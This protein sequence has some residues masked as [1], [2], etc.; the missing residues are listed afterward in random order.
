MAHKGRRNRQVDSVSPIDDTSPA[1]ISPE[2]R[3]RTIRQYLPENF[4]REVEDN[5]RWQPDPVDRARTVNGAPARIGI[6]PKPKVLR[7]PG[8]R[9]LRSKFASPSAT[10]S[11]TSRLGFT[12]PRD[13]IQCIRRAMRREVIFALNKRKKGAGAKRRRRNQWSNIDC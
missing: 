1:A 8:G 9:P 13:I 11:V 12:L 6:K 4:Y 10:A 5:R 7:G 3:P 2:I